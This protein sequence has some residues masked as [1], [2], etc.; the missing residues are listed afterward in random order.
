MRLTQRNR[1]WPAADVHRQRRAFCP[2]SG[3]GE[4]TVSADLLAGSSLQI[5]LTATPLA[6]S[7]T[8]VSAIASITEPADTTDS[9]QSNN[10]ASDGPDW[11]GVFRDGFE[12]GD[13][14]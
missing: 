13:M 2:G 11:R 14:P 3:T 6:N 8:P 12:A 7:E 10:L 1:H 4:V 9:Q 5:Q